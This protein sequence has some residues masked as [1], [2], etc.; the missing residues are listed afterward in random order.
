MTSRIQPAQI[1]R[2][3]LEKLRSE[4]ESVLDERSE[5][6]FRRFQLWLWLLFED[7]SHSRLAR[8]MQSWIYIC[9]FLS[10]FLELFMS[11]TRCEWKPWYEVSFQLSGENMASMHYA[12]G[13]SSA[14]YRLAEK[15][16]GMPD[17]VRVCEP[18]S[19][20]ADEWPGYFILDA[21]CVLSFTLEYLCR[22][23][24]SFAVTGLGPFLIAPMNIIDL[25]AIIPFYIELPLR[26]SVM[27]CRT[28][29][30]IDCLRGGTDLS[31][32][33][34]VR[35][36]RIA[37]ILKATKSMHGLQVLIRTLQLSARPILMLFIFIGTL[38][39]L[40]ASLAF[41]FDGVGPFISDISFNAALPP[42]DP[43]SN[44][45]YGVTYNVDSS[46][47]TFSSNLMGWYWCV[48]TLTS[49][50]YG[51][52]FPLTVPGKIIGI[53]AA[54]CGVIVL[55]L[56]ITIIGACPSSTSWTSTCGDKIIL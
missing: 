15:P 46:P 6:G 8:V 17:I 18:R 48:Q 1:S 9:I 44:F 36:I 16:A 43:R 34:V 4:A 52:M 20:M 27:A 10:T 25:L 29:G 33:K 26:I 40:F 41:A 49:V 39:A 19:S 11:Y 53:F 32:L 42:D 5:V 30:E 35:L 28:S 3:E 56:P 55:A 22:L 38:C 47:T 45:D 24:G 2:W 31:F 54:F 23:V 7:A 13:V 37:R 50:G 12:P 21:I 51:D 14:T